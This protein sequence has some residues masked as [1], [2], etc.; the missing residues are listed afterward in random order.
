MI[1]ID[2]LKSPECW[3]SKLSFFD[4]LPVFYSESMIE[5]IYSLI[6]SSISRFISDEVDNAVDKSLDVIGFP[7][8]DTKQLRRSATLIHVV[9]ISLCSRNLSKRTA[10]CLFTFTG[11]GSLCEHARMS[12]ISWAS[13]LRVNIWISLQ[14]FTSKS[15]YSLLVKLSAFVHIMTLFVLG[16]IK[17]LNISLF[18]ICYTPQIWSDK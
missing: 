16:E 10:R 3:N 7:C 8:L 9:Q 4:V 11:N 12:V 5:W 15:S 1:F 17:K 6:L 2:W 18:F 14:Q 13:I